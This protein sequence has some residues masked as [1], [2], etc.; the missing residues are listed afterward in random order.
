MHSQWSQGSTEGKPKE[1]TL[2]GSIAQTFPVLPVGASGVGGSNRRGSTQR[3]PRPE[4]K[5]S[6]MITGVEVP[7]FSRCSPG[8]Q[9]NVHEPYG[10]FSA[11]MDKEGGKSNAL[12][13]D[14]KI[15]RKFT[16]H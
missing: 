9:R 5:I 15:S 13:Q 4:S 2:T 12:N 10:K 11:R 7:Q 1:R 8:K 6:E 14:L 16:G 3:S